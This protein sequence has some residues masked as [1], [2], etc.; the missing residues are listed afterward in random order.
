MGFPIH[1][2]E[3][4]KA[5][6][7]NPAP[8]APEVKKAAAV[9][10]APQ[11]P[12]VKKAAAVKPAPQAPE[13]KKAAVVN[14]AP[15]A[16]EVK[17]AA[18]VN[19]APQAPEIKKAAAVKPAP[20]APEVKKAAAV[21]KSAPQTPEVKKVEAVI[22]VEQPK[23]AEE[24]VE[25]CASHK[26]KKSHG[27]Y[28]RFS[29]GKV[30]KSGFFSAYFTNNFNIL[31][32]FMYYGRSLRLGYGGKLFRDSDFELSVNISHF[33]P[34]FGLKYEQAFLKNHKW[35]PGFDASLL[36]G[37]IDERYR[38]YR[39]LL[40]VGLEGG[41]FIST[42]ISKHYSITARAGL[43]YIVPVNGNIFEEDPQ[44]YIS[45]GFKKF[46]Y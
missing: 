25:S 9:K 41:P 1:A 45:L 24:Q 35:F 10:P 13:V 29:K 16:P 4:T 7:V 31:E 23:V 36:F 2:E 14:P 22:A 20:Q 46:L 38:G 12:E 34:S 32:N 17:K 5:E 15:Q 42:F 40:A 30:T 43:S 37:I 33:T 28:C 6:V 18:A 11:A 21:V 44:F 27:N 8:Q 26:E 39:E 3:G 19:P